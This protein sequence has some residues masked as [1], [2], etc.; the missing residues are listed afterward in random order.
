MEV[1]G[2]LR[3]MEYGAADDMVE[4]V[5]V[6]GERFEVGLL[7]FFSEVGREMAAQVGDGCCVLVDAVNVETVF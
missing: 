4:V 6:E 3:E 5:V 1:C 7:E 2:V